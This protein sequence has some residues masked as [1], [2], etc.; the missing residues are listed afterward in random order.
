MRTDLRTLDE[1]GQLVELLAAVVGTARHDDTAD[2]GC[3]I[4]DREGTSTLQVAHQ[5]DELHAETQIG[6]VGTETLHGLMPGHLLELGELDTTYFTE[7]MT[8]HLL[9]QVDDIFLVD[10]RH[11][12]V[13]LRELRLPVGTQVFVAEAL[14][15]LKVPVE[16]RYHQ[17]LLEGLRALRQGVELSRIHA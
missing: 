7:Q 3:L 1:V 5:L 10:K 8:C 16:S 13:D 2:V 6:F 17:Q 4:E 15:Y 12:T 11:L 14:G 9:K